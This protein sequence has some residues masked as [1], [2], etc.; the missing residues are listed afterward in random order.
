MHKDPTINVL[1]K[2]GTK[3]LTA[4]AWSLLPGH[5]CTAALW[6]D[7]RAALVASGRDVSVADV[8]ADLSVDAMA[9]R[10]LAGLERPAVLVGFSMGGIV[11]LRMHALAP[12]R[13]SGLVL[14]SSNARPDMP[15]RAAKRVAHQHRARSGDLGGIVVADMLPGYFAASHPKLA[16]LRRAAIAMADELGPDVFV[17]Q[18]EAIR[19]RP[20]SRPELDR[21][22]C[23]CLIVGGRQDA[24]SLPEWPQELADGIRSSELLIL[25]DCG[26][27]VPL[28]AAERLTDVVTDWGR[29]HGF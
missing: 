24:M 25:E 6:K 15:E 18:S 10:N 23:P 27:F 2:T 5:L 8:T 1:W 19:T 16:D 13:V 28:E 21:I 7:L 29:R 17:R 9:E 12:D 22:G 14:I 20:D 26:H 4:S 3:T 11:A